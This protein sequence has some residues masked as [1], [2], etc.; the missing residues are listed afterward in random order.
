MYGDKIVSE[1]EMRGK[2]IFAILIS[3]SWIFFE[4]TLLQMAIG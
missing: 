3:T 4:L 1:E 2:I